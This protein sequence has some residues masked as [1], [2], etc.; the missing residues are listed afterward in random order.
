V[1]AERT[2]GTVRM[3]EPNESDADVDETALL[4]RELAE[5][6][7][8][9]DEGDEEHDNE[10]RPQ[11]AEFYCKESCQHDKNANV[12]VPSAHELLLEGEWLVCASGKAGDWNGDMNALNAAI[13]HVDSPS[14]SRVAKDTPGVKSEGCKGGTS[15]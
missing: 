11:Q 12:N 9:V 15:R 4:G 14:K 10:S 2:K 13:E 3:A 7:N 6:A 8:S 5:M 1:T